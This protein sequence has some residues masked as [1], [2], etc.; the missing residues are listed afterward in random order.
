MSQSSEVAQASFPLWGGIL[1]T[2]DGSGRLA[3]K[4]TGRPRNT[5]ASELRAESLLNGPRSGSFPN[6]HGFLPGSAPV[7]AAD[8][9]RLADDAVARN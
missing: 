2:R 3:K 1:P 7:V 6:Q 9:P 4:L 5:L 8:P